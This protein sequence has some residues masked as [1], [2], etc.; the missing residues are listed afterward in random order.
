MGRQ[1]GWG[2]QQLQSINPAGSAEGYGLP[3]MPLCHSHE[4]QMGESGMNV[5]RQGPDRPVA[6]QLQNLPT[7]GD[8]V[9][10]QLSDDNM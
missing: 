10:Q 4:S 7:A 9:Q 6:G 2:V 5:E 8:I 3:T 1:S